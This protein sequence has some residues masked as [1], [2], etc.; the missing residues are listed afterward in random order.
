MILKRLIAF[1]I[2]LLLIAIIVNMF[3]FATQTVKSQLLV[4]FLSA[5]MVTMLL[6]KDCINGKSAGK[7]I[8]K[9]EIANEKEGEKVSAVSCVVRNIFVVLWIIEILVLFISKEKRIGDYVAKTKVVSNS[10]V[11]KIKLDKNALLTILLCFCIIFLFM[12][13]V[14]KIFSSSSFEL[15]YWI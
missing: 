5:M 1:L 3:F 6:C 12:F 7:R 2:D 8:M 14:F 4:Q 9:I 11:E 10:K 13:F 15:L